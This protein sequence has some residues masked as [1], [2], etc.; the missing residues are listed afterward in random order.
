M[1]SKM[2]FILDLITGSLGPWLVAAAGGAVAL[3][4]AYLKGRKA[5]RDKMINEQAKADVEAFKKREEVDE[6]VNSD[7]DA[8]IRERLRNDARG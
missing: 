7:P 2:K 8:A 6:K 3:I 4:G 5:G 1:R